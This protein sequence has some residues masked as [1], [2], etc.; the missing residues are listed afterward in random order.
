MTEEEFIIQVK[1][2]LLASYFP[3]ENGQAERL[4]PDYVDELLQKK[5]WDGTCT[6]VHEAFTRRNLYKEERFWVEGTASM[7]WTEDNC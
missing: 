5:S 1:E 7:L 3:G 6:R 4:D 2:E